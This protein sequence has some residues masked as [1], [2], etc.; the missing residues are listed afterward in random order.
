MADK[1]KIEL[2][3]ELIADVCFEY[4]ALCGALRFIAPSLYE[5][6]FEGE[7]SKEELVLITK[8]GRESSHFKIGMNILKEVLD[9]DDKE[10]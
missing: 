10:V 1:E 5:S 2:S 9:D 8:K 6:T 4:S 3:D 7:F